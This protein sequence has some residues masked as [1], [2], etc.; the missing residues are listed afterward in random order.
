MLGSGGVERAVGPEKKRGPIFKGKGG[1][2]MIGYVPKEKK[3]P[4]PPV[5][6]LYYQQNIVY[7]QAIISR[8]P[9]FPSYAAG[10]NNN[11]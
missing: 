8:M 10:N 1:T 5:L 2:D 7:H 3:N 6:K 11:S 9:A 4:P